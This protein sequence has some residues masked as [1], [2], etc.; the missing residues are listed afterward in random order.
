[1]IFINNQPIGIFDSGIGGR[2]TLNHLQILLPHEHF[3]YLADEEHFPYGE[4]TTQELIEITRKNLQFML[5]KGVKVIVV[6]CNTVSALIDQV[7]YIG[8]VPIF[9]V[10]SP[11]IKKVKEKAKLFKRDP[12]ILLL[13]T[14]VTVKSGVYQNRLI[15]YHV[16]G[17]ICS[18][19]A[20]LVEKGELDSPLIEATLSKAPPSDIVILGC[21]HYSLLKPKITSV[22]SDSLIIDSAYEVV[23]D[24]FDYLKSRN[25]LNDSQE[26]GTIT[27]YNQVK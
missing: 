1:M 18:D 13:G 10:I 17:L 26:K 15:N 27:F 14:F 3:I 24:I 11:T 12:S 25:L 23:T 5:S 22:F 9:D 20:S 6:A 2:S 7:G 8:S 21:T 4:K 16:N 19:F